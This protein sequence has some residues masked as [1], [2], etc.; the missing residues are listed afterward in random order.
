MR[1]AWTRASGGEG[2]TC[3]VL[4]RVS[5]FEKLAL[6]RFTKLAGA[7]AGR[8]EERPVLRV[9]VSRSI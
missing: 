4:R 6:T 1:Y 2:C 3:R 7:G 9:Y 5:I 8:R